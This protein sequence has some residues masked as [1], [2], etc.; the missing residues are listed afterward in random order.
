MTY[1]LKE[2]PH[3]HFPHADEAYGKRTPENPDFN[4]NLRLG[5]TAMVGLVQQYQ[6]LLSDMIPRV[7]LPPALP[8]ALHMTIVRVGSKQKE[9]MTRAD[10]RDLIE[11]VTPEIGAVAVPRLVL[12]KNCYLGKDGFVF[13]VDPRGPLDEI[14]QIICDA[15]GKEFSP[16]EL[17]HATGFYTAGEISDEDLEKFNQRLI[18][19][20]DGV[21]VEASSVAALEQ[22]VFET[23]ETKYYDGNV[24]KEIPFA[25]VR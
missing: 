5:S 1:I 15:A 9:G 19:H 3:A 18:D 22:W 24:I 10:F 20:P 7:L 21:E 4:F 14:H 16:P 17:R 12:G 8:E 23:P 11:K 6:S 13:D 25:D 2:R